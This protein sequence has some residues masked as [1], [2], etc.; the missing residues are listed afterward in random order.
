MKNC[1]T[2]L[3]TWLS[4]LARPV[5]C[6]TDF[7]QEH[8]KSHIKLLVLA[9]LSLRLKVVRSMHSSF[10]LLISSCRISFMILP[11]SLSIDSSLGFLG[12][13]SAHKSEMLSGCVLHKTRDKDFR[14]ST[15]RGYISV[16]IRLLKVHIW[17]EMGYYL[18]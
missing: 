10:S 3:G 1:L 13:F 4:L 11:A 5:R 18:M 9:M 14:G 16:P 7:V 17:L 2:F 8:I 12:C 15:L 6:R